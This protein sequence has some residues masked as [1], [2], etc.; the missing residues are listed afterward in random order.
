MRRS[1]KEITNRS[2]IDET[3]HGSKVCHLG[4]AINNEPYVVPLSFGYDGNSLYFHTALIGKK[5][6]FIESNPRVCFEM[7]R[8]HSVRTDERI[9]CKWTAQYESVI[10]YGI[11][12]EL[13]SPEKKRYG[14]NQIMLHYSDR[15]WEF[16]QTTLK[17]TKIWRL[18]IESVT[19]KQSLID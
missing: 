8:N 11:I 10:G 4:L 1:D 17:R 2:L 14:L 15:E 9:A 6:E 7:I 5:I 12:R 16:D 13:I 18:D 19:G 3:I